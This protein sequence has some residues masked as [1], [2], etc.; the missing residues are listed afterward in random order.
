MVEASPIPLYTIRVIEVLI[1]ALTLSYLMNNVHTRPWAFFARSYHNVLPAKVSV[2]SEP[3]VFLLSH[4]YQHI[5]VFLGAKLTSHWFDVTHRRT[6]MLMADRVHNHMFRSFVLMCKTDVLFVKAQ[7]GT[8]R[9]MLN[10]YTAGHNVAMYLYPNT[11]GSG[12]YHLVRSTGGPVFFVKIRS[13]AT[14]CHNDES[15]S[16]VRKTFGHS[17][18]ITHEP[19]SHS[20]LDAARQ[21]RKKPKSWMND[22][23]IELYSSPPPDVSHQPTKQSS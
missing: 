20:L 22:C 6:T 7:G 10:A 2:G 8:T 1:V 4:Q 13:E 23:L 17:F 15:I 11:V 9:R 19:M 16:C 18:R 14:G 21:S 12:A 5:D 3:C